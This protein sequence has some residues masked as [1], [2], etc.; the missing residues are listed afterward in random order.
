MVRDKADRDA[1]R[2]LRN[3][4]LTQA[5]LHIYE[6][7]PKTT[8]ERMPLF[9]KDYFAAVDNHKA[10]KNDPLI[11]YEWL[12][13]TRSK[14]FPLDSERAWEEWTDCRR[15]CRDT[16]NEIWAALCVTKGYSGVSDIASGKQLE[17]M[18]DNMLDQLRRARAKDLLSKRLKNRKMKVSPVPALER[19]PRR[20]PPMTPDQ[21]RRRRP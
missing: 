14:G 2:S 21:T 19:L 18:R 16:L 7:G 1:S 15:Y 12:K 20:W 8:E 5:A 9:L 10:D 11:A 13:M 3:L 17:D 6:L 4:L